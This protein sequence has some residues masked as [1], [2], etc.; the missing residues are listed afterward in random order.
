VRRRIGMQDAVIRGAR[1]FLQAFLGTFLALTT[2]ITGA[3]E[4]EALQTAL[5]AA[6]WAGVIAAVAFA[7][8]ALEEA[9]GRRGLK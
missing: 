9:T 6:G 7:Q 8:N 4:G 3:P 5:V 2:G 1:T